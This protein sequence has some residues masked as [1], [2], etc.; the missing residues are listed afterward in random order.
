MAPGS[1]LLADQSQCGRLKSPHI[2]TLGVGSGSF[3]RFDFSL[4]K[5][6]WNS[7]DPDLFP[8]VGSLGCLYT[9][10]M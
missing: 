2:T 8:P 5:A 3:D 10:T 4:D 1:S 6:D 9:T 7:T